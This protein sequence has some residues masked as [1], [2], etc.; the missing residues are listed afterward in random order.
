MTVI[1]EDIISDVTFSVIEA[2]TNFLVH[3]ASFSLA[4]TKLSGAACPRPL[5]RFVLGNALFCG[6]FIIIFQVSNTF[7]PW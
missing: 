6:F 7:D 1:S 3:D 5:E 2:V 4:T